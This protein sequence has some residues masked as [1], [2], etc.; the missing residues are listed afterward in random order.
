MNDTLY[1]NLKPR[2]QEFIRQISVW[3]ATKSYVIDENTTMSR[4]DLRKIAKANGVAWAPAWIVKDADRCHS[5]G[6][7]HIPEVASYRATFQ[8]VEETPV[9]STASKVMT[10]AALGL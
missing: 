8:E 9:V 5:R 1:T 3:V 6:M 10:A 2:Q 4:G 7:Y